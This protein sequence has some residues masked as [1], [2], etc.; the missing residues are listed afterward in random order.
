LG[1]IDVQVDAHVFHA[2]GALAWNDY[3]SWQVQDRKT[4]KRINHLICDAIRSRYKGIGKPEP[5][6]ENLAGYMS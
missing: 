2:R 1:F 6:R 5:R 4:L 3:L